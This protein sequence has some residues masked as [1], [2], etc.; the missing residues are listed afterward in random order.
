[1]WDLWWTKLTVERE[2]LGV[3]RFILVSSILPTL[4]SLLYLITILK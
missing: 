1:M 4:I 3:L 2:F